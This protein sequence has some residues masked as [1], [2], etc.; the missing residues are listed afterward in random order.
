MLKP[1]PKKILK[2]TVTIRVCT[3]VDL[4][5]AT[6]YAD[7]VL[8]SVCVQPSDETRKSKDN[9]EVT[10]NSMLFVDARR[11]I[12]VGFDIAAKKD[13]SEAAGHSMEVL[14]GDRTY[15]VKSVDT[16]YDDEGKLHHWEV[17]L[18]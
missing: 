12:P 10:L 4:W 16:L 14:F 15:H 2:H 3:G 7:T 6:T 1:I 9:T 5:Q 18:V 17:G 13:E 8:A 11:S